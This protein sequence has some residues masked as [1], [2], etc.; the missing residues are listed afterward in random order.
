MVRNFIT[1]QYW[2][3][4]VSLKKKKYA[5]LSVS[6][7]LWVTKIVTGL[8]NFKHFGWHLSEELEYHEVAV[9][10]FVDIVTYY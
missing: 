2:I 7:Y 9:I 8:G 10:N 1:V 5:D 4:S 6:N 3:W